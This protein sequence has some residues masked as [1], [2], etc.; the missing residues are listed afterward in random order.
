MSLHIWPPAPRAEGIKVRQDCAHLLCPFYCF[1]AMDHGETIENV[2]AVSPRVTYVIGL[3]VLFFLFATLA[4]ALRV[5]SR[6]IK[7]HKLY[8]NDVVMLAAM[9]RLSLRLR[10]KSDH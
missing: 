4:V 3:S 10:K 9:V 6:R 1:L 2:R 5:W 8:I 7:G